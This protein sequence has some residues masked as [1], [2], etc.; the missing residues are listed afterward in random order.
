MWTLYDEI[1][2]EIGDES[3]GELMSRSHACRSSGSLSR[4]GVSLSS[5]F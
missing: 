4:P 5:V 2:I 3:E 1:E